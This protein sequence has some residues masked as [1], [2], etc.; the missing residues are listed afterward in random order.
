MR[1]AWHLATSELSGR[2]VRTALLIGAVALS[3]ALVVSVSAALASAN[4][5]IE[6][7]MIQTVGAGDLNISSTRPI[8][9]G[10]LE[11]VR[12]WPEVEH[13][14]GRL[15]MSERFGTQQRIFV[16]GD[17][18]QWRLIRRTYT[19]SGRIIGVDAGSE[20][21]V[22]EDRLVEGRLARE[23][24]EVVIDQM[25]AE[26]LGWTEYDD[27]AYIPGTI[28]VLRDLP[29]APEEAR[30]LG[31]AEARRHNRAQR[32]ELG[33]MIEIRRF[34]RPDIPLRVV[35]I[36]EQPPL[37][38]RPEGFMP[39]EALA[40]VM[41]S[42]GHVSE[43]VIEL[44]NGVDAEAVAEARHDDVA[45]YEEGLLLQT[46]AKI[47]SGLTKNMRSSEL[48]FV[49]AAVLAT[50]SATFIVVTG[51]T[52]AVAQRQ[53]ELAIVR[54]VGGTRQQLAVAQ[55]IIGI[56]LGVAGAVLGVPIGIGVAALLATLFS[57]H[58]PTGLIVP[59][60]SYVLGASC[61]VASGLIG[62][63]W[64][65]ILASRVSP[66]RALAS[67][68]TAASA[69]GL[70]LVSAM[71]VVGLVIQATT[72]LAPGDAQVA[73]WGYATTGLPA[74]V[75][76]Y[77]MLG[78][79]VILLTTWLLAPL[80]SVVL[81]LP[82]RLLSRAISATPYRFGFTAGAMM[83]GLGLMVAIWTN[84]GAILRDWLGKLEF[85]DAFV[86]GPSLTVDV[87]RDL[88]AL[89]FVDGTCAIST[90][91]IKTDAFGVAALQS[92]QSTFIAFEPRDFFAMTEVTWVQGNKKDAAARL[93][94]GGAVVVA[95]E[96]LVTQGLGLG[97]TF[98]CESDGVRHEFEIC[99]VVASPGL[100]VVS[101]FFNIGDTFH[102]QAVHAVFG[103][104]D[105][106]RDRFGSDVIHLIQID[107]ADEVDE[108]WAMNEI[109]RAL[110]HHPIFDSGSGKKIKE[111][112]REYAIGSLIVFSAVAIAAVMVASIGVANVIIAGIDARRHEMGVLRAVGA[113]R[114][115][116]ARLV[117]GETLLVGIAACILGTAMG[118]QGAWAG[119]N[120]YRLLLGL[121]LELR[122]AWGA[123]GVSWLIV[124]GFAL[125]AA[126]PAIWKLGK[127]SPR[128]LL[129]RRG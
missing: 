120:L 44:K 38:G 105:D 95:R 96:F 53:R 9:K 24:G 36:T 99:G 43:V 100:E 75:L 88:R 98:T 117:I 84:G 26:K 34:L 97:D 55:M 113:S 73:F 72:V 50:M 108:T 79:P 33:D 118:L 29:V 22:L 90:Y 59:P 51:L 57:T 83:A 37:G 121:L 6:M 85:P 63:A 61:A 86:N 66:L 27:E 89:D 46:S 82:P 125:G 114:G 42:Q 52:T 65:A 71:G 67:R 76:G 23:V 102:Q 109:D 69:G 107:L 91:P 48:G 5:A 92:Y 123:I 14:S 64:P 110:I 15:T 124:I 60:S 28:R 81:R 3:A 101:K 41:G 127:T 56:M 111:Q 30:T 77:F 74:M 20:E 47:T 13:V 4:R 112:I 119:Q 68:A 35:G 70:V 128:E 54:C 106:L 1:P 49:L 104:R 78:V 87:E 16:R 18:D 58:L 39:I 10:V 17:D 2:P 32:T 21:E 126:W 40:Q 116:L 103:T 19:T 94:E 122:P 45:A 31:A 62:A 25:L 7:R 115:I 8:D 12:T 129:A 80:V 11:I 93:E